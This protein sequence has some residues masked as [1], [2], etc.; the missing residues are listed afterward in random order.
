MSKVINY[1]E[2]I[3]IGSGFVGA[4]LTSKLE[5]TLGLVLT[6]VSIA[7]IVVGIISK[8]ISW[9]RKAREDGKITKEELLELITSIDPKGT[10]KEISEK[11]TEAQEKI[12]EIKTDDKGN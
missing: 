4:I 6:I 9:F 10:K 8:F 12:K 2:D 5:S 11:V 3:G 7:S 1:L